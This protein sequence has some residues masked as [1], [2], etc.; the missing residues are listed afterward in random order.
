M[1]IPRE[2]PYL[3]KLNS[4]YLDID[5]FTEHMQGEIGAG[6]IYCKSSFQENLIYFNDQEII[7]GIV[8]ENGQH[9]SVSNFLSPVLE[10]I[11]QR[12]FIVSVYSLSPSAVYFW[13][14]LPP[15]KRAKKRYASAIVSYDNLITRFK[16]EQFS[17][18]IDTSFK[19]ENESGLIFFNK[20]ERL[21]GSFSWGSG[22]LSQRQEDHTMFLEKLDSLEAVFQIGKF[23]ENEKHAKVEAVEADPAET[24]IN[25]VAGNV[26]LV[27]AMEEFLGLFMITARDNKKIDPMLLL[28]QS[29]IQHV[30]TYPFLDPFKG[31]F[32]YVDGIIEV[33][34]YSQLKK[35]AHAVIECVW[36]LV[37]EYNIDE[38]FR[39]ELASWE[40]PLMKELGM[41]K[42]RLPTDFSAMGE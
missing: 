36:E 18:F 30:D 9:A 34:D 3:D 39:D 1:L 23:L 10:S 11:R 22:G 2:K 6:C 41:L 20:G 37:S 28:R 14:Q 4:Y 35:M 13:G 21:G 29:F 19:E 8:Q 15:F 5:K 12:N 32:T 33:T 25:D 42:D 26:G 16:Q 24:D 31:Q 27:R 38:K 7:R 40:N 17:G